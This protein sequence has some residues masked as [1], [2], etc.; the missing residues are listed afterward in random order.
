MFKQVK[1]ETKINNN[2]VSTTLINKGKDKVFHV[3]SNNTNTKNKYAWSS[4]LIKEKKRLSKYNFISAVVENKGKTELDVIFWVT[5]GKGWNAVADTITLA[6][7]KKKTLTCNLREQ[8][9]DG[10]FKL[11]PNYINQIQLMFVNAKG[12][13]DVEWS[14]LKAKEKIN[15]W[16]RP[17]NRLD[18][19]IAKQT[20]PKAGTRFYYKLNA[21]SNLYSVVYLPKNWKPNNSKKYPVI[22]EFPGNVYY[23]KQCYSTGKPE[24]C[25]IGYG[26]SKGENAIWV[27]LPFVDYS[28]NS[29]A[30]NGWGNADN[31]ADYTVKTVNHIINNFGGDA[32]NIVLTGFSRG[33]IACGF[34]GLRNDEIS[35][36]WKGIHACQHYDGDGW[37]G[38]NMAEALVRLKRLKKIKLFETDNSESKLKAMLDK[39]NADVVYYNS[40]LKAHACDMFLDDRTSTLA[41]RTWFKSLVLN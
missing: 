32:N 34:I 29:I 13:I 20:K 3:F 2:G 17:K 1:T 8:F 12:F 35:N 19:P 14:A 28:K 11:N 30:E 39:V 10:T 23:T 5:S 38:A 40:G 7:G 24:D 4:I 18:V 21:G 36:L 27:S 33:A 31:T 41:L 22:V 26:M 37:K 16:D 25:V 6:A 15:N 9:P